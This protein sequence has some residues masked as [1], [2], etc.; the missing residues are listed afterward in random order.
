[1]ID[2]IEKFRGIFPAFYAFYNERGGIS[3]ERTMKAAKWMASK[4]INGLYL[5]GSSG[6]GMLLSVDERKKVYDSVLDAVGGELTI[7][8]HVAA[9]TTADSDELAS[10]A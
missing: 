1:M 6:E 9:N 8:A 5:T 3:R 4:G 2:N 7:I 10:Y